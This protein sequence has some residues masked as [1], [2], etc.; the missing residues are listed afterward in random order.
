MELQNKELNEL[1]EVI[2]F[3]FNFFEALKKAKA[4]DGMVDFKDWNLLFPLIGDAG[5]AYQGIERIGAAWTQSIQEDRDLVVAHINSRFT[6]ENK[7][8]EAK[9]EKAILISTLILE[10]A[11]N[12][13]D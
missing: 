7:V 10:L 5:V 9:I 1:V 2:D 8:T 4:N 12:L 3:G 13:N 6:L 11:L